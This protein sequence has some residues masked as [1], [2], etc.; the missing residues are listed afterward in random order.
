MPHRA[1]SDSAGRPLA[2][3]ARWVLALLSLAL[4]GTLAVA[5]G[6]GS[7]ATPPP[8]TIIRASGDAQPAATAAGESATLPMPPTLPAAPTP[9]GDA[10]PAPE[11]TSETQV[12]TPVETPTPIAYPTA[13]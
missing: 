12:E 9:N 2:G 1:M 5:C 8:A 10:Y 7:Q 13:G 3:P 11:Q 4:L 6:S